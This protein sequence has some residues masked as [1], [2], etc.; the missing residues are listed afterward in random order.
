MPPARLRPLAIL[1]VLAAAVAA[2]ADATLVAAVSPPPTAKVGARSEIGISIAAA[3]GLAL[4]GL[5]PLFV[6]LEAPDALGLERHRLERADAVRFDAPQAAFRVGIRPTA[7]GDHAVR[8]RIRAWVCRGET[9]RAVET[10][11][12]ARVTVSP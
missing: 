11:K 7:A 5:A 6:D 9:C 3:P 1:A 4:H 2:R 12:I 10:T 8:A